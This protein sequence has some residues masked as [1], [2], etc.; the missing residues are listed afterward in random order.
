ME[1]SADTA[2]VVRLVLGHVARARRRGRRGG[3]GA[4]LWVSRFV[5]SL[6]FGLDPHDAS[7]LPDVGGGARWGWRPLPPPAGATGRAQR[8]G[9]V[10]RDR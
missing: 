9:E 4:G 5:S 10:L 6:L 8:S 1:L 3:F 2:R 7:T